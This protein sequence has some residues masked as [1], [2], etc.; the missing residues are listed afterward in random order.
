MQLRW[1]T[2]KKNLSCYWNFKSSQIPNLPFLP[3]PTQR[4]G[5]YRILT[6]G[7]HIIFSVSLHI[8][9]LN[10]LIEEIA[11]TQ[12]NSFKTWNQAFAFPCHCLTHSLPSFPFLLPTGKWVSATGRCIN[13]LTIES[14]YRMLC[15]SEGLTGKD[16][17]YFIFLTIQQRVTKN[18]ITSNKHYTV[19]CFSNEIIFSLC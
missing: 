2:W 17:W 5:V 4:F 10:M 9:K 19:D 18:D 11:F 1:K 15:S 7:F 6:Q 8:W 13:D 16:L 14:S 12:E 3:G